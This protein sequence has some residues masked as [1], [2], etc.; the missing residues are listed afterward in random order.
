MVASIALMKRLRRA[1]RRS[2]RM[3]HSVEQHSA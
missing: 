3:A 1:R 2:D